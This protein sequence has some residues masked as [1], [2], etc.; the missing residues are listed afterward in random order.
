MP[1]GMDT[2]PSARLPMRPRS[3]ARSSRPARIAPGHSPG[4]DRGLGMTKHKRKGHA[5]EERKPHEP[6]VIDG[7]GHLRLA[8][9]HGMAWF[10]EIAM[11]PITMP[12][13]HAE[14]RKTPDLRERRAGDP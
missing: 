12:Q 14:G 11:R 2:L 6:E 9:H 1:G 8:P 13:R 5:C 7:G 10:R 3:A 4:L